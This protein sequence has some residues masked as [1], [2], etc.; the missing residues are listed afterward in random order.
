MEI[1]LLLAVLGIF[2]YIIL[3]RSVA[4]MTKTPLG[5]IWLVMMAPA[6]IWSVWWLVYG[7]DKPIPPLLLIGPFVLCPL[8]YWW[9]IQ[10]GRPQNEKSQQVPLQA[11]LSDNNINLNPEAN[12]LSESDSNIRPI[13]ATEEK[14][15]RDCFPWGVYYLQHIDYRPQAILCRGKL[16]A[17]P[18]DAYN[19]VKGNVEKEFGDRFLVLFQESLQGQPFFALVSNPWAKNE[20]Q[21]L[22]KEKLTR[23]FLALGLLLITLFTTTVIGSEL[24]GVTAEQLQA[25]SSLLIRGLPYSLGIITVLGIHELSHYLTTVRYNIR[26]T[27]PYFIPIPFFLGTFGAF[28][29]LRSPVPHRKALFDVAISGPWGGVLV[30]IPLLFWG[31]T[32][33][34]TVPID[35]KVSSLLNF[36][37]LNPRFSFLLAL[38]AKF[39]MGSSLESGLA[40][41][42]HPLA[43]AGY[44]GLIV[45]A[46]NLM[47]VGQLDG[48][49]M[50]HAMFGQKTALMVGQLTRILMLVL[51]VIQPDFL[52]WAILLLLM[53]V[54]AQPALNDVTELDNKRD[55]IGLVSLALL[56]FILLPLPGVIAGLLNI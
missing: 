33:S 38:I 53:P 47:P 15:L 8:L 1:W 43:V 23:P 40:I 17:V 4:N 10:V 22:E 29:S 14:V 45:T 16:R 35:P 25:N 20:N 41:H 42:L 7:E 24:S 13:T 52:L 6:I 18:E 28:I 39:A 32:L 48:G 50:I 27:L 36:E 31:L 21:D 30:T 3:K 54:N 51:A 12:P 19:T 49:N 26:A 46:L 37:S 9:L 11:T 2:T 5:L 44:V 55:F 34:D 56:L